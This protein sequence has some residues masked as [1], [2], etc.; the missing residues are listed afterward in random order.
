M[1][2]KPSLD[3]TLDTLLSNYGID[4]NRFEIKK[5]IKNI[6]KHYTDEKTKNNMDA[7]LWSNLIK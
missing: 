4:R 1:I 7:E 3:D 6:F 5:K 2:N